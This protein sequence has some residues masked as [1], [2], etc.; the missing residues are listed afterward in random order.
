[1]TCLLGR[2]CVTLAVALPSL[3]SGSSASFSSFH[4]ILAQICILARSTVL[5]VIKADGSALSP[6]VVH[7]HRQLQDKQMKAFDDAVMLDQPALRIASS[8]PVDISNATPT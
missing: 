1:M 5:G 6:V 4:S 2:V 7:P 3:R 8:P